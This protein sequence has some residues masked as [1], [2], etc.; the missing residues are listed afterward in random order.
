MHQLTI[1]NAIERDPP[2]QT[3][4]ALPGFAVYMSFHAYDGFFHDDLHRC[5][6]AHFAPGERR[7]GRAGGASEKVFEAAT[8]HG[9]KHRVRKVAQ[10]EQDKDA[11]DRHESEILAD[12]Q[13][14]EEFL[15][16]AEYTFGGRRCERSDKVGYRSIFPFATGTPER[17][18]SNPST[19]GRQAAASV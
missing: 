15:E 2:G 8:S 7:F 5:G 9:E 13:E 17:L 14:L 1:C 16:D 10:A 19:Y 12:A 18:F 6:K 3:K 4:I 11:E